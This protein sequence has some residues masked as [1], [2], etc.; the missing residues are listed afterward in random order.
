MFIPKRENLNTRQL[1]AFGID[2]D[3]K[4]VNGLSHMSHE[5]IIYFLENDYFRSIIPEPNI[6][7]HANNIQLIYLLEPAPYLQAGSLYKAL[8]NHF[9][10]GLKELGA[11][12]KCTD[13][14][15]VMRLPGTWH[16]DG[17]KIVAEYRHSYR[18][19]L[20]ELQEDYLPEL[21]SLWREQKKNVIK[22][23]RWLNN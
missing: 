12:V 18:Y 4:Y 11:D 19:T 7:I 5:G 20:R 13:F 16:K 6:I 10:T 17:M 23:R 3:Y 1:R 8:V 15:R 2:L 9:V 14:A 21:P 22:E